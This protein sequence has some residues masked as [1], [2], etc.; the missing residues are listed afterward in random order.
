MNVP[1]LDLTRQYAAIKS[2][3]KEALDQVLEQGI[4]IQGPEAQKL[5]KTLAEYC[6]A[7]YA[8]TISCGTDALLLALNTIDLKPGDEVI[9]SP[10]TFFASAEVVSYLN[11]KP[12]FV[13]IDPKT[14]CIDP[15]KIE[16]AITPKTKAIIPVHIFGQSADMDP[17]LEIARHH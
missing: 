17:I 16:A 11:G 7:N 4:Y 2:D 14:F 12:V 15:T 1:I 6:D 13:D 3:I 9:T 8:L 5:E 10:F